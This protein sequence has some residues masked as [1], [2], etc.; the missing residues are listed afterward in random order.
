[1][2]GL[3]LHPDEHNEPWL[4]VYFTRAD[5]PVNQ[6]SRFR[7]RDG[8][9][10]GSEE[11]LLLLDSLKGFVHN[12]GGLAFGHDGKLYVATGEGPSRKRL[13]TMA[14]HGK[15]L[16]LNPDG[17]ILRQSLLSTHI[18]GIPQHFCIGS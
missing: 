17:S 6:L 5:T 2:L 3:A 11:M 14:V 13:R 9:V 7:L 8:Q 1:M 12:G 4:Y 18:R 10:P 15:I 16:R